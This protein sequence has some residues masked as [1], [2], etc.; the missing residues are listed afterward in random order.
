M[1]VITRADRY[2]SGHASDVA[3]IGRTTGRSLVLLALGGLLLVFIGL[4]IVALFA[5]LP[6]SQLGAALGDPQAQLA[7]K[8]SL[9]SASVSTAVLAVLGVPLGYLLAQYRFPGRGFIN[10]IVYMPLVL[11]PVVGGVLLLLVWG[12][13]GTVEQFL[14][15]HNIYFVNELSGIIL[16][17]MFVSAPFV[18]VAARSAFERLDPDLDEAARSMGADTLQVFWLVAVPLSARAIMAGLVLSWMRAFGEFGATAIVAYHPFSFPVYLYQQLSTVG[19]TPVLPMTL[20]A[21]VLGAVVLALAAVLERAGA[22]AAVAQSMGR[23]RA[24]TSGL[25]SETANEP[26]RGVKLEW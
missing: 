8:T 18:V 9:F 25:G 16:C 19:F 13:S 12:N 20:M 3:R 1:A 24:R 15:P 4:P 6:W 17:Q 2:R 10:A 21:V 23:T 5:N 11:P 22:I 14:A 7:V 26:G